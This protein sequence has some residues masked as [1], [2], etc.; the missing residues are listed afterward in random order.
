MKWAIMNTIM[1]E[2]G[3]EIEEEGKKE[4]MMKQVELVLAVKGQEVKDMWTTIKILRKWM[5][6]EIEQ[7][8]GVES[9]MSMYGA[10]DDDD[11]EDNKVNRRSGSRMSVSS[12]ESVLMVCC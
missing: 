11:N 7:R 4:A 6:E 1:E 12:V 5:L 8:S 2:L 10:E 3:E 9:Q